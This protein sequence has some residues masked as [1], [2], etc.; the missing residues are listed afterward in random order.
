MSSRRIPAASPRGDFELSRAVFPIIVVCAALLIVYKSIPRQKEA[1]RAATEGAMNVA[2][3]VNLVKNPLFKT[4]GANDKTPADFSLQ[5]DASWVYTGRRDESGD[6]GIAFHS[7]QDLDGD[8]KRA[9]AV[10]QDV[11]GF[12]ASKNRW[13]RFAF[14]GLPEKNFAVANDDLYMRVDFYSRGGAENLEGVTRKIYSLI[15]RDRSEQAMNGPGRDAAVWKT[16]ALDFELP[17]PV[18]DRL[19][20]SV[21]FSSGSASTAKDSDFYATDFSLIAIP[22]HAGAPR[23]I[24]GRHSAAPP[25]DDFISLGRHWVYATKTLP[26]VSKGVHDAKREVRAFRAH[27]LGG[28]D[29]GLQRAPAQR[30]Q[31]PA[32]SMESRTRSSTGRSRGAELDGRAGETD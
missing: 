10:A 23:P 13:F 15:E 17:V 7:G 12:D 19:R 21:G 25:G 18:V 29:H 14:R 9:G 3:Q 31:R 2:G 26:P 6:R 30:A 4:P 1:S 8:G 24:A 32:C 22:E 5:G 28:L 11:S 20:L 27:H 16:Y